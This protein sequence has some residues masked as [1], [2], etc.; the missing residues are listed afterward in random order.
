MQVLD[1]KIESSFHEEGDDEIELLY[2]NLT[3][4][5]QQEMD[6]QLK[7]KQPTKITQNAAEPDD[8]VIEFKRS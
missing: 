1:I 5:T 8:L 4:L 3:R 6:I 7:F 2:Y